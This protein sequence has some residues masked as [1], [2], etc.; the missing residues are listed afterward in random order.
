MWLA[1]S[2]GLRVLNL[3]NGDSRMVA[4]TD[5]GAVVK[6]TDEQSGQRVL[7]GQRKERRESGMIWTWQALERS[8]GRV[9]W[10]GEDCIRD[11][12]VVLGTGAIVRGTEEIEIWNDG[13]GVINE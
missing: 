4:L 12:Y 10:R 3:A 6:L 7:V 11:A 2:G 8:S 13:Q 5:V 9:A 1:E